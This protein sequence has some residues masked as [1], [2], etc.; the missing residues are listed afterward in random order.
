MIYWSYESGREDYLD[1]G[2]GASAKRLGLGRDPLLHEDAVGAAVPPDSVRADTMIKRII[3]LVVFLLVANAGVR[4]G[5]RLL[6]RSAVQGRRA[7]DVALFGA[8]QVRRG[9]SGRR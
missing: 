8:R 1:E 7:R 2:L 6:P 5:D 3:S 9:R 4:V